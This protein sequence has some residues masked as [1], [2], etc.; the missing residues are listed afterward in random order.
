MSVRRL[1]KSRTL[2]SARNEVGSTKEQ[3][4]NTQSRSPSGIPT[5]TKNTS[6]VPSSAGITSV[7]VRF[8]RISRTN[9][10]TRSVCKLV[11]V[12]IGPS[13]T[14]GYVGRNFVVSNGQQQAYRL[15]S[16][17]SERDEARV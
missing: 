3:D 1:T 17:T 13:V 8:P 4:F 5:V 15:G 14:H 10:G 12:I 16:F 2:G 6:S 9:R 11:F 7:T